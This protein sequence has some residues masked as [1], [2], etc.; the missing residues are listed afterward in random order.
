MEMV[1]TILM[2]QLNV[3]VSPLQNI[4]NS[5]MTLTH[6]TFDLSDLCTVPDESV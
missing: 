6:I 4:I 3:D 5:R 1:V 2:K